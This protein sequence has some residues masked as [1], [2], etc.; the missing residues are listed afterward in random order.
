LKNK[1]DIKEKGRSEEGL[2]ENNNDIPISPNS[3]FL[4]NVF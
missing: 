3:P 1:E 4:L 2:N